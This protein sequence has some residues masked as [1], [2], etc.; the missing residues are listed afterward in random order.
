ML[1][2]KKLITA[3]ALMLA[4][5][6]AGATPTLSFVSSAATGGGT[7]VDV[8]ISNISD[9]YGYNFSVNYDP[10]LL[11]VGSVASGPF[12]GDAQT[13]FQGVAELDPG[14]IFFAYGSLYGFVPGISGSGTLLS[15][16]VDALA[17]GV[18]AL[19]FSDMLFLDSQLGD[20]AVSAVDGAIG[21][22]PAA[23]PEPASALLLGIGAAALL[24]RRR[25]QAKVGVGVGVA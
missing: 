21:A 6:H 2:F 3:A 14:Q 24:G 17:P 22:A 1:S 8:V 23:V 20:I 16:H 10:S 19:T 13:A 4:A 5:L 9:L 12:L 11:S 7:D 18:A 25:R 15:F